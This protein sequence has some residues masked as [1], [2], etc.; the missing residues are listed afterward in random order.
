MEELQSRFPLLNM[1][2]FS[3][4][5]VKITKQKQHP[6]DQMLSVLKVLKPERTV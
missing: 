5:S 1:Q 2:K 3:G 4:G 6:K